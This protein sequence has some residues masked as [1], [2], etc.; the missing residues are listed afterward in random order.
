MFVSPSIR[1]APNDREDVFAFHIVDEVSADEMQEM[2]HYMDTQFD[3]HDKVSMILIFDRYRGSESGASLNW[4]V[5]K[6][7]LKSLTKVEIYALV[8]APGSV[9]RLLEVFGRLIPVDAKAFDNEAE[10]WAYVG[11]SPSEL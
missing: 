6:T 1:E 2:S 9:A 7:R 10:A 4:D 3:R 8:N 5:I 11:S